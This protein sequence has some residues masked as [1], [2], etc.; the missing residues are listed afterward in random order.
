[1]DFEAYRKQMVDNIRVEVRFERQELQRK[2]K[3]LRYWQGVTFEQWQK[4]SDTLCRRMNNAH[5]EN[6]QWDPDG[7]N[8]KE[9]SSRMG[10]IY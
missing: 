6:H 10:K 5:A 3:L 1:M 8:T 4:N 2:E 9:K 7:V